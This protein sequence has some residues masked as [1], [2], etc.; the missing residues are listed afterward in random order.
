MAPSALILEV[1]DDAGVAL[2]AHT[3]IAVGPGQAV[4]VCNVLDGAA[5]LT[6]RSADQQAKARV[7][8][9]D[10]QRNLCLLEAPDLAAPAL[11]SGRP[12][13]L[14]AVGERV[15]A[16]SNALGLGVGISEGVVSGI[17]SFGGERYIQFTAP[18]S[19]GSEGGALAD[20]QGR[21]VGVIDYRHRDGQNV[22]FAAP[23][24]WI[25]EIE[26]RKAD[27]GGRQQFRD[28]AARLEREKN[29]PELAALARD[30]SRRHA[31]DFD[32]WRWLAQA[33][34]MQTD[35]DGEEAAWRAMRRIDPTRVA[36]G[37]GLAQ[38]L[39]KRERPR[40]SLEFARSLLALRQED[41]DIWLAIGKAELALNNPAGAEQAF[42]KVISLWPWSI[43][44][45]QG[46]ITLAEGRGDWAAASMAL[47]RIVHLFPDWAPAQLRLIT[48]YVRNKR[49]ARALLV[50]ERLLEREPGNG[51]A[52]YFKGIVLAVLERPDDAS[53]AFR[54]S[55]DKTPSNPA[56]V[57]RALAETS[58]LLRRFPEAVRVYR[59][60][61]RLAP[62]NLEGRFGLA[63]ALKDG[64]Y[65]DEAIALDEKLVAERPDDASMWRQLGFAH[66][67]AGQTEP[68]IKALERSL[69]LDPKQGWTWVALLENY[70][71]T[72]RKDD[73]RRAYDTLRG[74]DS[75]S[76]ESAYKLFVLPY[77]EPK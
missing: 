69:T 11:S 28:R 31:D 3:A 70:H 73:F 27:D 74:I 67:M 13:A 63:I 64:G 52:W 44:A 38:V 60:A 17:R 6:L 36:A 56:A 26:A 45:H 1:L 39:L 51:D 35:P 48:A 53:A 68:S 72:G 34:A 5:G 8:W 25:G 62:K 14:P 20:A 71:A 12:D 18:V 9:R 66:A 10:P 7:G 54:S 24:Q 46:L 43:A 58:F 75:A 49:P 22:N 30:W 4:S 21:L 59:E 55:L 19:P 77:E 42:R 57:S 23:A 2:G 61:V 33:A 15:Y 41:A 16:V 50:V 37:V 29:W 47:S 76:A 32:G 40:E 65:V